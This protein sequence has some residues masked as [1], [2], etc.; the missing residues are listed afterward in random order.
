MLPEAQPETDNDTDDNV[1]IDLNPTLQHE[2]GPFRRPFPDTAQILWKIRSLRRAMS[3]VTVSCIESATPDAKESRS[4]ARLA[5][6]TLAPV[7][8]HTAWLTT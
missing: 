1:L 3:Y 4:W 7:V 5:S 8:Q 6:Q 2:F